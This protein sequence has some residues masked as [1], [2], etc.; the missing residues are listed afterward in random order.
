MGDSSEVTGLFSERTRQ[1]NSKHNVV[2]ATL[3]FV[4]FFSFILAA[5]F[6]G[7]AGSGAAPSIFNS[8]VGNLSA[9]YD[10]DITPA[11][12]TFSIWAVIY[13]WI[14]LD[15]LTLV[16]T[17]WWPSYNSGGKVY[18]N[19]EFASPLL[20]VVISANFLLNLTWI[21]LWDREQVVAAA[22]V[23]FL[24][25]ATG[26]GVIAIMAR[27]IFNHQ[28]EY[29]QGGPMFAWGIVYYL[30]I[31]GWGVYTTW[32]LIASLIN[33]TTAL[34]YAAELDMTA[35]C[36][37]ALSLLVIFHATWFVLENTVFDKYVRWNLT[38]YMVVIWA[39]YGIR[40][41]YSTPEKADVPSEIQDFVLAILIIASITLVLRFA[42]VIIRT[43][44][45]KKS[46]VIA[47]EGSN[48]EFK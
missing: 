36:L 6:N 11:G 40:S 31:D 19:P 13:I 22:V 5:V 43:I 10:L 30:M 12:F 37:A 44:N 27:N 17:I 42:I 48:V 47:L 25:T 35:C 2:T 45:D 46:G 28:A 15:L 9:K 3:I 7:L 20:M 38:P 39:S 21:F 23:L 1:T 33:L 32:S 29:C 16:L 34:V 24:L 14:G 8:T 26:M 41:T 18:Q 4:G